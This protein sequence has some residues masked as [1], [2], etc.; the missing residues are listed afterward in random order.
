MRI[1]AI[2]I[3]GLTSQVSIE[4][5]VRILSAAGASATRR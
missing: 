2:V 5:P 4:E 1:A 3:A